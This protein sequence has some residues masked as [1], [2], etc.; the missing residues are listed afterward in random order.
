MALPKAVQ[1]EVDAANKIAEEMKAA[2]QPPEGAKPE[3]APPE[4][5]P[6]DRQGHWGAY[7][8]ADAPRSGSDR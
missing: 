5:P 4:T 2:Q 3:G 7:S 6:A 8:G 1:R